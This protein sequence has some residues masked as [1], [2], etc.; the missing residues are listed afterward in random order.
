MIFHVLCTALHTAAQSPADR[1]LQFAVERCLIIITSNP[2]GDDS[3]GEPFAAANK[4]IIIILIIYNNYDAAGDEKSCIDYLYRYLTYTTHSTRAPQ[5]TNGT[6]WTVDRK[7]LYQFPIKT[8]PSH[9]IRIS[10][11]Y[12]LL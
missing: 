1:T 6:R 8:A 3:D 9:C 11:Y 4:I 5:P 2:S 12:I 10:Y 7:P